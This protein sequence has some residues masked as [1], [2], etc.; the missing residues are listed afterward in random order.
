[1]QF[2]AKD[3]RSRV[4]ITRLLIKIRE[5]PEYCRRIGVED[6]SHFHSEVDKKRKR[7]K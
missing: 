6:V 5:Q 7:E 3:V 4:M 2:Y 1:M